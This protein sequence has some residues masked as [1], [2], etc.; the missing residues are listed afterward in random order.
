MTKS[1]KKKEWQDGM[2]TAGKFGVS[3]YTL[4]KWRGMKGFPDEASYVE[5]GVRWFNATAVE[6]WLRSRDKSTRGRPAKWREAL[7]G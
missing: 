7:T 3:V 4:A 6:A 1:K 2:T 5:R